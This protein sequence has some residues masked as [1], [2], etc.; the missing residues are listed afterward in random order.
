MKEIVNQK[1]IDELNSQLSNPAMTR[2]KR[3]KI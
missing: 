2:Q 3:K 1:A